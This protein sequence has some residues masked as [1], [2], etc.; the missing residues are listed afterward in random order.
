MNNMTFNDN[1]EDENTESSELAKDYGFPI[2]WNTCA[3]RLSIM[4]NKLGGAYKITRAKAV[5][6]GL[7]R[8]RPQWS[9]EKKML[10][11]LSAKEMW[12]YVSYWYGKPHK[13]FPKSGSYKDSAAFS[14]ARTASLS[15]RLPPTFSTALLISMIA[16]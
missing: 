12:Q 16:S 11:I 14:A 1:D 8:N 9:S 13:Q 3:I 6:A 5:K 7:K 10:L 15:F 2:D 4:W